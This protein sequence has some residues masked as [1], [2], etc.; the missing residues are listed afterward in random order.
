MSDLAVDVTAGSSGPPHPS[1][2]E[3][4]HSTLRGSYRCLRSRYSLLFLSDIERIAIIIIII[5]INY[6]AISTCRSIFGVPNSSPLRRRA[7]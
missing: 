3:G 6:G 2:R 5:I 4:H 1:S 7:A